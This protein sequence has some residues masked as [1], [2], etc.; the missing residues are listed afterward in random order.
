MRIY[1]VYSIDV[2]SEVWIIY[3]QNNVDHH[4]FQIEQKNK[5]IAHARASE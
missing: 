2:I 4:N 5:N 3:K 1:P